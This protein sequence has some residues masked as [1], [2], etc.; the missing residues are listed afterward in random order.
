MIIWAMINVLCAV[1]WT[2]LSIGPLGLYAKI[3]LGVSA[4]L[5]LANLGF[6]SA[7]VAA[8]LLGDLVCASL[9]AMRSV[10]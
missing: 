6:L 4:L 10:D 7:I 9:R 2:A 5:G 3:T 1:V 8:G